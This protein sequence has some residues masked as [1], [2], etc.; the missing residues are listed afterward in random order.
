MLS[1]T[2]RTEESFRAIPEGHVFTEIC[3][4]ETTSVLRLKSAG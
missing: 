2:V 4:R 1:A 3:M